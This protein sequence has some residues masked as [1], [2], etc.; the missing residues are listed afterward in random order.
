MAADGVVFAEVGRDVSDMLGFRQQGVWIVVGAFLAAVWTVVGYLSWETDSWIPMLA[1]AVLSC[2]VVVIVR[3]HGDP[4][5]GLPT[6][7]ALLTGPLAAAVSPRC[8]RVWR[9]WRW[10]SDSGARPRGRRSWTGYPG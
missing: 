4:L 5:P 1:A 7:V 3:A 2:S 6:L 10:C 8:S 9:R